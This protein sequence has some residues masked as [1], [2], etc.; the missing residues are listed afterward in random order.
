MMLKDKKTIFAACLLSA[1]LSWTSVSAQELPPGLTAGDF[2]EDT[3]KV[4]KKKRQ[5]NDYSTIGVEYGFTRNSMTFNPRYLQEPFISPGYMGVTYTK[6]CRMMGMFPFFA[7][8]VGAFYGTEGY[9]FKANE[10]TGYV[11]VIENATQAV[12]KVIEVPVLAQFHADMQHF[13]MFAMVGPYGGYRLSIDRIDQNPANEYEHAFKPTDR[14]VDY[15]LHA[16]AGFGLVF[17]PVELQINLRMRYSWSNI[18]EPDHA[19][20]YYYRF[21]YPFDF[22]LTAGL[23]FQL[24]KRYGK[25]RSMIKKEAYKSV[26]DPEPENSQN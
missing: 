11:N 1:L 5:M 8:Q 7:L 18:Y 22:M 24:G 10:E 20:Q 6:Y 23:H 21:G 17:S 15:G 19:S 13:K 16:G 26:F 9:R 2:Q 4:V 25:T 12:Y 3:L 14:Q